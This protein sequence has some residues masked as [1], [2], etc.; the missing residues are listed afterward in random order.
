[1]KESDVAASTAHADLQNIGHLEPPQRGN[2]GAV[3]DEELKD[4]ADGRC[5][6]VTVEPR[7]GRRTID[8]QAHG[9]DASRSALRASQS[10]APSPAC[11][12]RSRMRC[13]A[14]CA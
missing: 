12:A 11:T 2:P 7:Q 1:M 9:R 13:N 3:F 5:R 14:A 10:K 8:N 4:L 6:F